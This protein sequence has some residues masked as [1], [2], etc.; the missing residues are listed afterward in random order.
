[1]ISTL[2][3]TAGVSNSIAQGAKTQ[4]SRAEQYNHLFNRLNIYVKER[5]NCGYSGISVK[6]CESRGCCFDANSEVPE[7][8]WCFAPLAKKCNVPF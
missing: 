8:P 4:N 7:V 2:T 6:E 5:K 1:M 3:S